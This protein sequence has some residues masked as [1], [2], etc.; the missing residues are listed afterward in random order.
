LSRFRESRSAILSTQNLKVLQENGAMTRLA[1][2]QQAYELARERYQSIGVDVESVLEKLSQIAISVHC[3]Q[4]DDVVGFEGSGSELGSGLAVTG[5]YPGRAST[6]DELRCDL[7]LA[8]SLIP[9]QHRLNLHASYGEF[10]GPVDRD[11]IDE[12]HF[13]GWIDWGRQQKIALDFNPTYFAHP[14][15]ADGFT[16]AHTDPAIRKFWIDHGIACRKVAAAM[17]RAQASPCVHNVW[18]PDGFKDTPANRKAPRERLAESLDAIFADSIDRHEVLDAVECKLF[19]IGSESYVVGSH[20]FYLGYAISRG[21]VLCLDA[22]H[23]H[24]TEVISDKISSTLMYVPELLL[25]VSRGVRWDSDHV[26][27]L[28]DELQAIAQ[29]IVRGDFLGRVHIGLDFFDASI[30]RVAAWVIGTRNVLKALLLAL[31]EPH[32]SLREAEQNGDYTKRLAWMEELKTM[33]F[34]GVWDHYCE[35]SNVPI[36][37]EWLHLVQQYEAKVMSRR[38]HASAVI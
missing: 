31:L 3:W 14:K 9:G 23:F 27:T 32:Q 37:M 16:L 36:G 30:N 21:K 10:H 28:S 24:P 38:T 6:P 29:E 12:S 8:Y 34:A 1:T 26:V 7:E 2:T 18:V 17:G 35:R 33:P 13:A 5:N 11:E 15:A 22:G 25:H 4:G 20:E 19:G